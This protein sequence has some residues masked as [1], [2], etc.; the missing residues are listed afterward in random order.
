MK[1]WIMTICMTVTLAGGAAAQTVYVPVAANTAGV[2]GTSWHSDLQVKAGSDEGASFAVELLKS[3]ENNSDPLRA[4]F[5]VSAGQSAR[6]RDVVAEVFG[7]TGNGALRV[8]ATSGSILVTSRTFNDDPRGSYGQY[9][10]AIAADDAASYGSRLSLLQLSRSPT[11]SAGFR[12]NLGVL[13]L[14]GERLAV[15]VNLFDANGVLLGTVD[16]E[17]K[18]FE[19]RQLNDIFATV[20]AT[21]V[22]DGYA[23]VHTTTKGG[24]FIAYASVVDNRSGDAIFIPGQV[25]EPSEAEQERLVVFEIFTRAT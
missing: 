13:N 3:R 4:E 6:L 21:D 20:G 23:M 22:D 17:L 11:T 25:D 10:P 1:Q 12:T 9:V 16:R 2:A 19:H 5:N 15:T 24:R 14:T 8:T 18:K 7:F